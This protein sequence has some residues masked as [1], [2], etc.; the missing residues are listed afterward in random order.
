MG[1]FILIDHL[2]TRTPLLIN[3]TWGGRAGSH[4]ALT[5]PSPHQGLGSLRGLLPAPMCREPSGPR[6]GISL[7]R[8]S[9]CRTA[10]HPK[11]V[12]GVNHPFTRPVSRPGD[13]LHFSLLGVPVPAL[14]RGPGLPPR[15]APQKSQLRAPE[16]LRRGQV[17]TKREAPHPTWTS[18]RAR[19]MVLGRGPG[20]PTELPGGDNPGPR[21]P[22][23]EKGTTGVPRMASPG[24]LTMAGGPGPSSGPSILTHTQDDP[25]SILPGQHWTRVLH[26]NHP[27]TRDRPSTM[28][29]TAP[30]WA[31][32]QAWKRPRTA[33]R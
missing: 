32:G 11:R 28:N 20:V 27:T 25:A 13:K 31:G 26:Q 12:H 16:I 3:R 5:I 23:S 18:L 8:L 15:M 7:R 30:R 22:R 1:S 4:W 17:W 9:S 19:L 14:P 29:R 24:H 10:G 6:A 33:W 21:L 2:I